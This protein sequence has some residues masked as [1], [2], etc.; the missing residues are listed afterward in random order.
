M[1]VSFPVRVLFFIRMLLLHLLS[2]WLTLV[3]RFE[4]FHKFKREF[5]AEDYYVFYSI[6]SIDLD[7]KRCWIGAR[8][9]L[10]AR[11]VRALLQ[12]PRP[13][14]LPNCLTNYNLVQNCWEKIENLFF[15]KKIPL[16]PNQCCSIIFR[17]L[18]AKLGEIQHWYRGGKRENLILSHFLNLL[19]FQLFSQQVVS[20]LAGN[21]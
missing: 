18:A 20:R 7:F 2:S 9:A 4:V 3:L 11:F 1:F 19:D 5:I 17:L 12:I 8:M 16:H 15:N 21:F 14:P 13:H 6:K 10:N